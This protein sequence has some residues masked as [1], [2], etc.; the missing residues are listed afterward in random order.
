MASLLA[1]FY[2]ITVEEKDHNLNTNH[3]KKYNYQSE[4]RA[5]ETLKELEGKYFDLNKSKDRPV[6]SQSTEKPEL[7]IQ[8]FSKHGSPVWIK[9]EKCTFDD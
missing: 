9:L 6:R 4:A 8:G 7:C 2:T 5:R 1:P 3:T